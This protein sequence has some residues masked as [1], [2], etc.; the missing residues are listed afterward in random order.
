MGA[1]ADNCDKFLEHGFMVVPIIPGKKK[2][3]FSLNGG[4][5]YVGLS[6]WQRRKHA[7]DEKTRDKWSAGD[8]GLGVVT[9]PPSHGT[10]ALDIDV[11]DPAIVAAVMGLL[12]ETEVGKR[13]AKGK[14]LFYRGPGIA[15]SKRWQ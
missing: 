9:G 2:P 14:T 7:P 6:N 5:Y 4:T 10:V 15:Q 1:Y 13:G 8:T 3:G 12:P 11:D